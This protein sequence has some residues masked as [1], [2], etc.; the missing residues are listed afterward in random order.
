MTAI[1]VSLKVSKIILKI[2]GICILQETF[3]VPSRK[4]FLTSYVTLSGRITYCRSALLLHIHYKLVNNFKKTFPTTYNVSL[5]R[6]LATGY[7]PPL[8][9]AAE[10]RAV[11]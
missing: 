5:Y 10:N 8:S 9:L 3:L 7:F 4:Q 2:L 11:M 6:I 1:N